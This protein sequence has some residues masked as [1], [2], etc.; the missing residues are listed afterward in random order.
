[1]HPQPSTN[2]FLARLQ[3]AAPA[4]VDL[5]LEMDL[6]VEQDDNSP[7][8]QDM[9]PM[10]MSMP[11]PVMPMSMPMPLPIPMSLLPPLLPPLEPVASLDTHDG[12]M[13]LGARMDTP[14]PMSSLDADTSMSSL[15][16]QPDL[17]AHSQ[18]H[19]PAHS[20]SHLPRTPT[21]RQ[22]WGRHTPVTPSNSAANLAR[23]G[24]LPDAAGTPDSV[25]PAAMPYTMKPQSNGHIHGNGNGNGSGNSHGH[26]T[27]AAPDLT[28][29]RQNGTHTQ[30]GAESFECMTNGWPS[31]SPPVV[32][33]TA[34]PSPNRRP[35]PNTHIVR[36]PKYLQ[37][38]V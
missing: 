25:G 6:D 34:T 28:A 20:Q 8:A 3:F 17:P 1:M 21:S 35:R 9:L 38:D 5:D 32:A 33:V 14:L 12:N 16:P 23:L 10:S 31:A 4:D 36:Q 18:S 24:L 19:H 22:D 13:T 26:G 2:E 30:L 27:T 7:L 11:I 37:Q 29:T 15:E